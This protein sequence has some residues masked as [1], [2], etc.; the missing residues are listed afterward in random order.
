MLKVGCDCDWYLWAGVDMHGTPYGAN[1]YIR[2]C[3]CVGGLIW[4]NV[5]DYAMEL[6][7]SG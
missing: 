4:L 1:N 5:L 6:P 3:L 2:V 7:F